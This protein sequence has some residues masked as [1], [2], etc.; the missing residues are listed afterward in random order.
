MPVKKYNE[1]KRIITRDFGIADLAAYQA[2]IQNVRPT[3]TLDRARLEALSPDAIDCRDFWKVCEHLFGN[4]PISNVAV[5]PKVGTLAHP[6]ETTMDANR[7]NLRFAKAFGITAFLEEFA[8]E[9]LGTLEIGPGLGS[10]KHYI[11]THTSHA[12]VGFDVYPRTSGVLETTSDGFL[13]E[14]F[15]EQHEGEYS[16]VISSNVFQHLSAKQRSSNYQAASR[17]LRKGG[18]LIFNLLV[19][20]GKL[21]SF[22]RDPDG[23]AWCD[24]YCQYTLIPRPVDLY[25]EL[26]EHYDIL[27]VTQRYD[28]TFN[29]VV[30]KRL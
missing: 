25:A 28:N 27:Y 11:E 29:F 1:I 7:M 30:Q 2:F 15:L 26:A 8:A 19:D 22:M 17:L 23:N 20:T 10:L 9:R 14:A 16:Y 24:H 21:P 6:I 4:D 12:Y 3:L 18:L 5:P 13:P